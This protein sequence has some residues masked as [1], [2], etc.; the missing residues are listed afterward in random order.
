MLHAIASTVTSPQ[1]PAHAQ[2]RGTI[3]FSCRDYNFFPAYTAPGAGTIFFQR[4][5]PGAGTGATA[6]KIVL[7]VSAQFEFSI[8]C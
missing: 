4:T 1:A 6:F 7:P 8:M 5:A 2:Y 3:N